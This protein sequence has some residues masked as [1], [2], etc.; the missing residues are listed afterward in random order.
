MYW[1][2]NSWKQNIYNTKT[3]TLCLFSISI[4]SK[5]NK[6]NIYNKSTLMIG[7][8][9][10]ILTHTIQ[11]YLSATTTILVQMWDLNSGSATSKNAMISFI[12][13]LMLFS[14][15]K[16]K[17]SSKARRW[18]EISFSLRQSRIVVRWRC[19]A[20]WSTWTVLRRVLR[21]TY[22]YR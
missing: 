9:S 20:L 17:E 21:A 2:S 16:A 15:I 14:F 4:N 11:T 10:I 8:E 3:N 19:T 1:R 5:P 13:V 18:M 7:V 12:I 22:L 6:A